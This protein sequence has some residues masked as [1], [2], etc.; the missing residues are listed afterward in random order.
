MIAV[1][2]IGRWEDEDGVIAPGQGILRLRQP[3]SVEQRRSRK[4]IARQAVHRD[5]FH[6]RRSRWSV[7]PIFS[8]ASAI[9]S[10]TI[11]TVTAVMRRSCRN[12]VSQTWSATASISLK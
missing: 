12:S 9:A 5:P 11:L 3:L 7:M 6:S 4:R 8:S 1:G 2:V 10:L